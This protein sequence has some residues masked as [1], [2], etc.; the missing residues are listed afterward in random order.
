M[1]KLNRTSIAG[2]KRA[3]ENDSS[4]SVDDLDLRHEELAAFTIL[5]HRYLTPVYRFLYFSVGDHH[6]AEDLTSQVFLAALEGLPDYHHRGTFTAWLFSIARHKV[7]DHFR[8][9]QHNISFNEVVSWLA[10]D[11]DLLG[12]VIDREEKGRL[13]GIILALRPDEQE[14]LVLRFAAELSFEEIASVLRRR[15]SA[16]KM[17]LYRLLRRVEKA[18][19]V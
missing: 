15:P 8:R 9:R 6:I 12:E 14:L 1:A 4:E 13:A 5:Y 17:Q 2:V 7:V 18:M 11:G 10:V 16:V 3:G 19:N